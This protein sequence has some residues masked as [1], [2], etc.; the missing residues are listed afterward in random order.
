MKTP[1]LHHIMKAVEIELAKARE[2][3]PSNKHLVLALAEESG[4]V[5][6]AFLDYS[7]GKSSQLE[8]V[9]ELVQTITVAVRLLQEG[10]ADLNREPSYDGE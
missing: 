6:K 9:K 7:Q 2:K 3:F 8:I 5:V 4:E 10:D 1:T